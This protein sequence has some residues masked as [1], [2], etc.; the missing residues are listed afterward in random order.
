MKKCATLF[1]ENSLEHR[2][3]NTVFYVT[4]HNTPGD[5]PRLSGPRQ[6]PHRGQRPSRLETDSVVPYLNLDC[7]SSSYVYATKTED[8]RE[9]IRE[10]KRI[11]TTVSFSIF[12]K[13]VCVRE[14]DGR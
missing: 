4:D 1:V 6:E 11:P 7:R 9:D 13:V 5:G 2:V 12:T 14:V 3:T 10:A 8:H